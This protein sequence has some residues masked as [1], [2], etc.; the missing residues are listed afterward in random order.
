MR[1]PALP[2]DESPDELWFVHALHSVDLLASLAVVLAW[3]RK[4]YVHRVEGWVMVAEWVAAAFFLLNYTLRLL[5]AGLA[6]SAAASL[7]AREP[8]LRCV[9]KCARSLTHTLYAA[10]R[11][12]WTC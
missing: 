3:M 1:V 10:R 9:R 2:Q 5:R 6:P 8:R 7:E 4:S 11:G 12:S